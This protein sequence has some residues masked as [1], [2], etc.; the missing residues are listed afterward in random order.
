MSVAQGTAEVAVD[1]RDAAAAFVGRYGEEGR[2][3]VAALQDMEAWVDARR[4]EAQH[5]AASAGRLPDRYLRTFAAEEAEPE[6]LVYHATNEYLMFVL[7]EGDVTEGVDEADAAARA[8]GSIGVR[9][10]ERYVALAKELRGA[11]RR[12]LGRPGRR[13]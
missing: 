6:E 4:A 7:D 1:Y 10:T 11:R 9:F 2:A 5:I 12:T 3:V 8:G 13:R